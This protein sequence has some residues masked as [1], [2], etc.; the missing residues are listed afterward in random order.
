MVQMIIMMIIENFA[1]NKKVCLSFTFSINLTCAFFLIIEISKR[2]AEIKNKRLMR[3]P[4]SESSKTTES[5]YQ[6]NEFIKAIIEQQKLAQQQE[7][8]HKQK[9]QQEQQVC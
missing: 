1:Q 2:A 5:Q 4:T 6:H 8:E 9:L 7:H 3:N